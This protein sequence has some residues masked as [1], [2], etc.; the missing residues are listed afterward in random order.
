L[1]VC[2]ENVSR[3][4]PIGQTVIDRSRAATLT[5]A[6]PASARWTTHDGLAR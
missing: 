5:D 3:L 4:D 1:F 6:D 2:L